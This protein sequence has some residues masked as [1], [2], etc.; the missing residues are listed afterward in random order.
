MRGALALGYPLPM[1]SVPG[2]FTACVNVHAET[3]KSIDGKPN[4]SVMAG[5]DRGF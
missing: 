1:T 3:P 4:R 5:Q 2:V